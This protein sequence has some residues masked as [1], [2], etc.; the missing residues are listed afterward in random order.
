MRCMLLLFS[1]VLLFFFLPP[2]FSWIDNKQLFVVARS[3]RQGP[4]PCGTCCCTNMEENLMSPCPRETTASQQPGSHHKQ[5]E[6]TQGTAKQGI[7]TIADFSLGSYLAPDFILLASGRWQIL[8]RMY[9]CCSRDPL[10]GGFTCSFSDCKASA[11][12]CV[13]EEK[14]NTAQA[15]LSSLPL[16]FHF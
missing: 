4:G 1:K 8:A 3:P 11:G 16:Q 7:S 9:T 15:A 2:S 6:H 12:L 5:T 10:C 13:L 14:G